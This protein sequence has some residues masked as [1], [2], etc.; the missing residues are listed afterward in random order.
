MDFETDYQNGVDFSSSTNL[1][2]LAMKKPCIAV[3]LEIQESAPLTSKD[4]DIIQNTPFEFG[5]FNPLE[6]NGNY[7]TSDFL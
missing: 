4:G 1:R 5:R 6:I 7:F 2:C 3:T